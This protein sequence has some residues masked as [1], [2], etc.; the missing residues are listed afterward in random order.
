LIKL[1]PDVG[2]E[3]N[4]RILRVDNECLNW[5]PTSAF[6][7]FREREHSREF[8][9]DLKLKNDTFISNSFL[10]QGIL[11]ALGDVALGNMSLAA[12]GM[13]FLVDYKPSIQS[14]EALE[15]FH[16]FSRGV[17]SGKYIYRNTLPAIENMTY[18]LRVV[19]YRANVYRTFHGRLFNILEGDKRVDLTVAFRIVRKDK[20]GNITLLWKELG[21]KDSPRVVPQKRGPKKE[22]TTAGYAG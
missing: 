13:Q 15:Q 14:Q 20:N 11:V 22:N 6:Y 16:A 10:S 8:L 1:F 12:D 3:D 2:C 9:A 17:K 4:A 7:S 5:I 18:A 19:A 21:R